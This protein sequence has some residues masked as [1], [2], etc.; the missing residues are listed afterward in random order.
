MLEIRLLGEYQITRD[1]VPAVPLQ[2][3]R[4][5][6][7]LAYLLL[8]RRAPQP[9]LHLAFLLWP[10]SSETQARTNLRNLLHQLRRAL[11]DA[12][13]FIRIEG[14]TLQW[15][16]DAPF[17]LDV[18]DFQQALIQAKE[19]PNPQAARDALERATALYQGDLLPSSYEEWLLPIRE[20]LRQSFLSG[21]E[22]LAL[23]LE[24]AGDYR[25]AIRHTQRL[26]QSEP[27][28]EATYIHLMRLH[29]RSGDRAG[30]LRVYQMCVSVLDRELRVEPS[31][32][33]REAYERLVR[34]E[35]A[36]LQPA[37]PPP[38]EAKPP[39]QPLK[40]PVQSTLFVGRKEEL[41]ELAALLASPECRLL[42]LVGP[43]GTGKTRLALQ[44]AAQQAETLA[45]GASLVSLASLASADL[46]VPSIASA[47]GLTSF[48]AA[49]PKTQLLNHLRDRQMLL[50]LDNFEHLMDGAD[51]LTE[52][53]Q[54][55]PG[56][57]LLVTSRERLN[58]LGEWLFEVQGLPVPQNGHDATEEESSALML[59]VQSARRVRSGFALTAAERPHVVRICQLVEGMPLGIE[60]AAA[61]ARV[62]P[63]A[64]IAQE[65]ERNIDFLAAST[66]DTPSRHRSMR[67]I[68]DHSWSLLSDEESLAL[69]RLSLFRGGFRREAAQTVADAP[70]PMLAALGDKSLLR[71]VSSGRYD[72]HELVRQ[73][74]L[75]KLNASGDLDAIRDRY[76]A[77]YSNFV[78]EAAPQLQGA[79]QV[80][81]LEQL[82]QELDN[83]RAAFEWSFATNP[84]APPERVEGG[85]R[86]AASIYRFWQGRG[87]LVEGR[88]WLERGVYHPAAS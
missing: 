40:L 14:L 28:Q 22:Q 54:E 75:E 1:G 88:M 42:T 36:P 68:F 10:D 60:L 85:L 56:V 73:Y 27:L 47:V 2:S 15:R 84:P 63:A 82:E 18:A 74:A 9:R 26:L 76:L 55:A 39:S 3:E 17:T 43:G 69:A 31:P 46:L 13:E 79:Q 58:L 11:H 61:W 41:A 65:I 5:Q 66:R 16:D 51:L 72:M 64:E 45:N 80:G 20:E 8:H 78:A 23:L 29:A 59:F 81:W 12:D 83:L 57:K 34:A 44:V 25:A 33:T 49:D 30:V 52:I 70:L 67:A 21:L 71:R 48:G 19:A 24:E 87:H 35:A 77:Y 4:I 62:L 86:A 32:T 7:L 37:P 53:L 50:L 38:R 6:S